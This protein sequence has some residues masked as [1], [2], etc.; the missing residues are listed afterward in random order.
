MNRVVHFDFPADDLER[1]AAFYH[2]VF[3]WQVNKWEGPMTY[4]F[5]IS[6]D[7][8]EPGINGAVAPRSGPEDRMTNTIGVEDLDAAIANI[9]A[10]G[11]TIVQPKGAVPGV[12]YLAIFKDTEGNLL[13]LMQDDPEAV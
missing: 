6:G 12:G 10:A 5:L 11:G 13:G 4:W 9:V 7:D 3:G 8:S 1:A 2:D